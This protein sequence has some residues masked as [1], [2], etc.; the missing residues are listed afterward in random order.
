MAAAPC[1][2]IDRD[3]ASA[4]NGTPCDA[5]A[6]AVGTEI[7]LCCSVHRTM[8]LKGPSMSY[9]FPWFDLM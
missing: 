7:C 4:S 8:V 6:E 9:S 2:T 3:G 5:A 1:H